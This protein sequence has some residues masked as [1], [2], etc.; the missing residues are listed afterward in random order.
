M[1]STVQRKGEIRISNACLFPDADSVWFLLCRSVLAEELKV[2]AQCGAETSERPGARFRSHAVAETITER[3]A[4]LLDVTSK[5]SAYL[6]LMGR[7]SSNWTARTAK[8]S[9]GRPA[10][11]KPT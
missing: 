3:D 6:L 11:T 7:S 1:L 5:K 2:G 4:A 9:P 8:A 10:C